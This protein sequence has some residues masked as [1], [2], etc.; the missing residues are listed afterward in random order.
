MAGDSKKPE[1]GPIQRGN[2]QFDRL[3]TLAFVGSRLVDPFIQYQFLKNDWGRILIERLRGTTL[4]QG[5]PLITRTPLDRLGLSPYR[6]I[7]LAMS[8]GSMLKQNYWVTAINQER[9]LPSFGLQVGVFN[10]VADTLNTLFFVCAQ[11]SASANGEHFPQTPLIAGS[12]LYGAG[13]FVE[14]LSEQQR[15]NW[16]KK[17]ENRGQVYMGGLWSLSRHINYFGYTVWRAGYAIAA[18]GFIWGATVAALSAFQFTQNSIPE[19][20]RYM[21]YKYGEKYREY[22]RKTPYQFVPYLY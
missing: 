22:E 7:I 15:H 10:F 13:I 2:K 17:E 21:E 12:L 8:V 1:N 20:Q 18:G 11:T 3:G 16:K 5:P 14:W 4:S 6:T 19:L 9:M